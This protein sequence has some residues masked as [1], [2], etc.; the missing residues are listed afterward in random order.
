M[1][2]C[3]PRVNLF[4]EQIDETCLHLISPTDA[5]EHMVLPLHLDDAGCLL[6][7]TTPHT[8]DQ[9]STVLKRK[10]GIPFHFVMAET[11][12]LE[13]HIAE[14]YEFEGVETGE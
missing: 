7:A 5:W 8:I 13:Q 6:C 9:A 10:L 3:H 2:D 14:V 4:N 11:H 1:V 12:Q